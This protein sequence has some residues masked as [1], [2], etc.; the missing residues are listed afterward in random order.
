MK[1]KS[2]AW[3]GES[4]R[5]LARQRL[6][7]ASEISS[8]SLDLSSLAEVEG[9][10][11]LW[12]RFEKSLGEKALLVVPSDLLDR[13]E[14]M[15]RL[16]SALGLNILDIFHATPPRR[17]H[18]GTYLGAGKL[19]EIK[20]KAVALKASVIVMELALSPVQVRN[21]E[22][23]FKCPVLDR[24][25]VILSIFKH[26][27][28]TKLAKTQV[29]LAQ[30]KYLQSR[31]SGIWSG[32]SRQSGGQGGLMGRG[33]G[34][35]RLELDRRNI[36]DRISMLHKRLH[37]A[38]K[39][40]EA[41]SSR[42]SGLPRVALVGYTNA[43]K[44]TLMQRLTKAK[45][46]SENQLFSTLDTTVRVMTPPTTPKILVSDTVGFVRDLPHELV[47]SFKSTLQEAVNS[48]VLAHVLDISHEDWADQFESTEKVLEEIGAANIARIFVLNKTDQVEKASPLR[49]AQ[50]VREIKK[51]FPDARIVTVSALTGEGV[52]VLKRELLE[53]CNAKEPEWSLAL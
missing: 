48:T 32:L 14:E 25:A 3:S 30:L 42:R 9:P 29:E 23:F 34:E 20:D 19:Q 6:Q 17:I 8:T 16:C 44:S 40:F 28:R 51:A 11:F 43:G 22:D 15:G 27:A 35:T 46:L 18:A 2:K 41:Q 31:L 39:S 53:L 50:A 47:V 33:L 13:G 52:E 12:G 1:K 36:K 4:I 21:L 38:E 45:V 37:Q 26:H 10:E 5:K 24:H 7:K 49:R